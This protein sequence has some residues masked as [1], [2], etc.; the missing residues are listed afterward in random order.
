MGHMFRFCSK[1]T[2]LNVTSFDTSKVT[3]TNSST[4]D[5]MNYMFTDCSDLISLDLSSFN[6]AKVVDMQHM[7]N[8]CYDLQS[9]YV[10]DGWST[11][12]VTSSESMFGGQSKIVG[13]MGT[14][15][16]SN[17]TD[18]TYA[19]IDGGAASPGYFINVE[20]SRRV[21]GDIKDVFSNNLSS[22]TSIEFNYS[23]N[24]TE[25]LASASLVVDVSDKKDN[26]VQLYVFGLKAYI[27]SD[28][29]ILPPSSCY[30]LFV[31]CSSLQ[32]I[33]LN[34]FSA[35][36]VVNMDSMFYYLK[37]LTNITFGDNF[38][39]CNVTTM[40]R[41]FYRC[42][43]LTSLD[44]SSF[45][46]SKVTN[47]SD[48]FNSCQALTSLDLTKFITSEVTNMSSMFRDC[49][50]LSS[51]DVSSFN[52]SNVTNMK[53]MFAL[54]ENLEE[55]DV[56]NFD[57]TS[58]IDISCMFELGSTTLSSSDGSHTF[59]SKIKMLKI[60][61][62][63]I[64]STTINA[65][66]LFFG[67]KGITTLDV[68]GFDTSNVTDMESMFAYCESLTSLD[69]SS[70]NT[71][72]VTNMSTMFQACFKLETIY[73]GTDWNTSSVTD[74]SYAFF[75][76]LKLVGGSGTVYSNSHRDVTYAHIDG[77]AAN[78]GYL[79]TK[80]DLTLATIKN[81]PSTITEITFNTFGNC[82][83][84]VAGFTET[85]LGDHIALYVNSDSTKAYILSNGL[86][87]FPKSSSG[88]FSNR[89][90]LLTI[91]FINVD[92]SKV[93][94][95]ANMFYYCSGLTSLDLSSFNT[96]NVENMY[97]MFSQ[98]SGLTSLNVAS[99][100]TSN[101]TNMCCMFN[102]CLNLTELN[103][104]NFN[105]GNA[106]NMA[107]MFSYCEKL[108][109][110]DVSNFDT[111]NVTTMDSMFSVLRGLTELDLSSFNTSKVTNMS[112]MFEHSYNI[113]TIYVGSDWS[114]DSVTLSSN[115]FNNC[116]SLVGYDS[117]KTD[118]TYATTSGYLTLKS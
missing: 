107:A 117:T 98:C 72:R 17:H 66:S 87:V 88:M 10:G 118:A 79:S 63:L 57:T 37:S 43:G 5:G 105:T 56:S 40:Y 15:V 21:V 76:C 115:M 91:N 110:L 44:V 103:V 22:C 70:F 68:S 85:L 74:G 50:A 86:T 78:P 61:S 26:S 102:R 64:N 95:M 4:V 49:R 27:L 104:S 106:T 83:S 29:E 1:L 109:S 108:T 90:T 84:D 59:D 80:S 101:V 35:I 11:A 58:A 82:L 7:F 81:L 33:N 47:M 54:C 16:D 116:T 92:T 111:S 94:D 28:K 112:A 12:S 45:N 100:N 32:E 18:K 34:N 93:T 8:G 77:G 65:S 60:P 24:C 42:S 53:S 73:V 31:G 19:R 2:S 75:N 96:A 62:N 6:T 39:T 13:G 113:I 23:N 51:L 71:G 99:F 9:I 46:T 25:N 36:A 38:N 3:G 114:T 67:C 30:R 14:I 69:L 52:T 20:T 48:M 41:M 55:L 97:N 89:S